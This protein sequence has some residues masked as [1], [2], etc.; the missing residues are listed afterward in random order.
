[1]HRKCQNV[2]HCCSGIE[3][4]VSCLP[5]VILRVFL[6]IWYRCWTYYAEHSKASK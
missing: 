5:L 2:I 3:S 4:H 6:I 1:M